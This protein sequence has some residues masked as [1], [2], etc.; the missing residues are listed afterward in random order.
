MTDENPPIAT[1]QGFHRHAGEAGEALTLSY[2][3]PYA[4]AALRD[5]LAGRA[6]DG[7]EWVGEAHY[8]R[9]FHWGRARG[10]F[11]AE[12]RPEHHAFRVKLALD[13]PSA[14]APVV[15]R[16]RRL[17][18]LDA[19]TATIQAH[20]ARAVPTLA[21]TE[22]L[23]LPGTWNPFEAGV[24]AILGQQISVTAARR[25]VET[26]VTNLGKPLDDR[27]C[28]P[29][30]EAI[31]A[32]DL[33]FLGMPGSRRATLRRFAAWYAAGEAGDEPLAWTTLKGIG[34][35]TARYAA[36]RGTGHPDIWLA[37]DAAVRRA[38]PQLGDTDPAAAA[39]WRSYLTLQLW[40]H[41]TLSRT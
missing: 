15:R 19:D 25:L 38:L 40:C 14:Q 2:R 5:F 8:G 13:D 27:R 33:D 17:L 24:R 12:H 30:P 36:L 26:L 18:D 7:L 28:F 34:P 6:I 22:G 20:L 29:A 1:A 3:P 21:L 32:S 9:T 4:W 31:A 39:P 35:W 11:T 41:D 16:I 37:G 23:R 10:H